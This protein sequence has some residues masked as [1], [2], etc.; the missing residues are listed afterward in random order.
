MPC[1]VAFR[2]LVSLRS[3]SSSALIPVRFPSRLRFCF[4]SPSP[5]DPPAHACI[6]PP[7]LAPVFALSCIC[8]RPCPCLLL[9]SRRFLTPPSSVYIDRLLL[10]LSFL[11][12]AGLLP[13]AAILHRL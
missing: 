7:R 5:S 12:T 1:L 13:R 6:P 9:E 11:A 8:S 4:P 2:L 3:S 10:P